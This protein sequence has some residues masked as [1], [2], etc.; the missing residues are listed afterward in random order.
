MAKEFGFA[1]HWVRPRS[2]ELVRKL[3]DDAIR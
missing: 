2:R 3:L 1:F